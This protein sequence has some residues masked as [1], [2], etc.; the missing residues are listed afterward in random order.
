MTSDSPVHGSTLDLLLNKPVVLNLA[1][2]ANP[3]V[4]V[5]DPQ[6]FARQIQKR[7]ILNDIKLRSLQRLAPTDDS[8]VVLPPEPYKDLSRNPKALPRSLTETKAHLSQSFDQAQ[9]EFRLSR[10]LRYSSKTSDTDPRFVEALL[11]YN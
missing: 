4:K 9:T 5:L 2:L 11:C 6:F 3:Q 10:M 8:A 1:K 7:R